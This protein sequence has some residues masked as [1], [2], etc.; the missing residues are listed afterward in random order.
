MAEAGA[1][2]AGAAFVEL[3]ADDAKLRTGLARA[4]VSLQQFG[5]GITALGKKFLVISSARLAG[6]LATVY[7]FTSAAGAVGKMSQRTGIAVEALSELNFAAKAS[8]V[9]IEDLEVGIKKMQKTIFEASNGVPGAV[10]ALE[11]FGLTAEQLR[12]MTGD[13]QLKALA[14]GFANTASEID[15]TGMALTIFGKSGTTLLP[16]LTKGSEGFDRLAQAAR[17]AGVVI[18]GDDVAASREFK[19]ELK[20]M[21]AQLTGVSL[22][23]GRQILPLVKEVA[24]GI[25]FVV[26]A[27]SIWVRENAGLFQSLFKIAA[28]DV[29]LSLSIIA[30]GKAISFLGVG[31]GM[32]SKILGGVFHAA[33]TAA[34]IALTIFKASAIGF[35]AV[36]GVARMVIHG[37][38]LIATAATAAVTLLTTALS[39]GTGS[40]TAFT[41]AVAAGKLAL[42]GVQAVLMVLPVAAAAVGVAMFAMSS[43]GQSALGAFGDAWEEMKTSAVTTFEGIKA[44]IK[45][46]D[47]V[48]AAKIAWA[49]LQS[50]WTEVIGAL[51]LAWI[52][53]QHWFATNILPTIAPA[54]N[55]VN[56]HGGAAVN[57]VVDVAEGVGR[58]GGGAI[59]LPDK[60]IGNRIDVNR[61]I[62]ADPERARK[63]AVNQRR[64]Q[65]E[66]IE[67]QRE[68]DRE[69]LNEL[70]DQAVEAERELR[71]TS[72]ANAAALGG[73]AGAL[74]TLG[75]IVPE[76]LRGAT[77][78]TFSA[79]AARGL[80]ADSIQLEQLKELR[81][82]KAEAAEQAAAQLAEL[83]KQPGAIGEKMK[84][85]GLLD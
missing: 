9:E 3:F 61:Q 44:A 19:K 46:G 83:R 2:R 69:R 28:L 60:T 27:T 36:L 39:A 66:L 8:G 65:Q 31:L 79:E 16:L 6:L 21:Q 43:Q 15:R 45:S 67:E 63:I 58:A 68:E 37:Y 48:L 47:I 14:D 49:G 80:G 64:Q 55:A 75:G 82:M 51:K 84:A 33:T 4:S 13:Q 11:K 18:D 34:T 40:V 7:Q 10:A 54:L 57:A 29:G 20:M 76:M 70:R 71:R 81:E 25:G 59:G 72:L 38:A 50:A 77:S 73:R 23:I 12:G 32:V 17:E 52:D 24:A 42:A 35:N 30:V 22:A 78:G 41:T 1:I 26:R 62:I 85:I 56:K 5:N 53:F 74:G